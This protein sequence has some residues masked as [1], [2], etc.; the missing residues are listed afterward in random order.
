MWKY[1]EAN[2]E[3]MVKNVNEGV[4]RV[5]KSNRDYA[6]IVESTMNEY[7]NQRQPC[8][9]VKVSRFSIST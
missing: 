8:K 6:F 1:M 9:T 2:P 5:S 3:V 7:Y 4:E